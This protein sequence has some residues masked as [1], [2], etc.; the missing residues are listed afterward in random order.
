MNILKWLG[1]GSLLL[2]LV[3]CGN[4][5]NPVTRT[6]GF[7]TTVAAVVSEPEATAASAEPVSLDV[8]MA[9]SPETSE[10]AAITF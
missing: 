2:G 8:V 3:A 1:M 10:P 9:S 5:D 6:D 7:T 4:D